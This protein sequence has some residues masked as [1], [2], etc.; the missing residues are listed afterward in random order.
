MT[1]L[2][3]RRFLAAGSVAALNLQAQPAKKRVAAII[4][5][6]T[7]D[8]GFYSHAAVIVGRL[9]E[10]YSPNG[11]FTAPRARL[12]SM[13]TAQ[14]PANDLSRARSQK[15]GFKIYP[16]IKDAMTLAA[17]SAPGIPGMAGD[18]WRMKP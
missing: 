9:L 11:V 3:R 2:N 1:N 12:V 13:C 4:T 6:Y 17:S 10:G 15:Y 7:Q 5:M 16:T 8:H 14:P 18:A